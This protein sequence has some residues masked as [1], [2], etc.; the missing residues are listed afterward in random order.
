MNTYFKALIYDEYASTLTEVGQ[1][2]AGAIQP[3]T[4]L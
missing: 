1:K 3:R 2:M 4:I